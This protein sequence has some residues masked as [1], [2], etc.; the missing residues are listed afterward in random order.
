MLAFSRFVTYA[1]TT[2]LGKCIELAEKLDNKI[3]KLL[4]GI[5]YKTLY[6][7]D[8]ACINFFN[9]LGSTIR[10]PKAIVLLIARC[11]VCSPKM[12]R[13]GILL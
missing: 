3:K 12:F 4:N 1:T 5:L 8:N 7:E 9:V 6:V 11:S 2:R 13:L 10:I